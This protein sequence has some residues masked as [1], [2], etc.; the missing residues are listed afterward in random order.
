M[1][2]KGTSSDGGRVGGVHVD[3]VCAWRLKGEPGVTFL[4][5][6]SIRAAVSWICAHVSNLIC[7]GQGLGLSGSSN[8]VAHVVDG[9]L[10]WSSRGI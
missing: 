9:R 10:I 5:R 6:V 7:E 4:E 2:C 3:Y 1:D 8:N